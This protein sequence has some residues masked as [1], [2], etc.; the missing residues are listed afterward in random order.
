ME[1]D[2]TK[3][4]NSFGVTAVAYKKELMVAATKQ[5]LQGQDSW[6]PASNAGPFKH[7]AVVL[8]GLQPLCSGSC[9]CRMDSSRFVQCLKA[10]PFPQEHRFLFTPD[11]AI[12]HSAYLVGNG[13]KAAAA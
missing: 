2:V 4:C 13:E 12:T 6:P 10:V 1:N 9:T 5:G 8:K 7:E 11:V 3:S